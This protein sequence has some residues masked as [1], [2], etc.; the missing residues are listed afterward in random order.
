MG[1]QAARLLIGLIEGKATTRKPQHIILTPEL[2]VRRSS[3]A[4]TRN[5]NTRAPLTLA[6]K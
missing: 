6:G 1:Q 2:V 5:V 3:G 4:E